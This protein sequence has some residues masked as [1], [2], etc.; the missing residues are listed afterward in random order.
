MTVFNVGTGSQAF[1]SLE[2][3]RVEARDAL[4]PLWERAWLAWQL[5]DEAK[6]HK[7]VQV[8]Q[9]ELTV[10]REIIEYARA[11]LDKVKRLA[12]LIHHDLDQFWVEI[13]Q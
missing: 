5:V 12:S 8:L 1:G 9:I 6:Y 2:G 3:P 10:E 11:E 13:N 7:V 4:Q